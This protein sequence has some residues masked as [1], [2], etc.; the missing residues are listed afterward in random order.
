M[1]CQFWRKKRK[2]C[3]YNTSC[4][5]LSY[6]QVSHF[7]KKK[8]LSKLPDYFLWIHVV[9]TWYECIGI[10][11]TH[12]A[13]VSSLNPCTRYFL[14]TRSCGSYS[15]MWFSY[16]FWSDESEGAIC[17]YGFY[18]RRLLTNLRFTGYR[19]KHIQML[20]LRMCTAE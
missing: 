14:R 13:C 15:A 19:R 18:T 8:W 20:Y 6:F 5:I 3:R 1:N 17:F 10:S 7:P 11:I 9:G 2:M 12:F 16:A 4:Y